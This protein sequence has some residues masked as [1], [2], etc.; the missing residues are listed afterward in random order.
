MPNKENF[1]YYWSNIV[2][3]KQIPF[4]IVGNNTDTSITIYRPHYQDDWIVYTEF[5]FKIPKTIDRYGGVYHEETDEISA[6]TFLIRITKVKAMFVGSEIYTFCLD[7]KFVR[8]KSCVFKDN[9]PHPIL[10]GDK[11]IYLLD[12]HVRIPLS[13]LP[14]TFTDDDYDG[15]YRYYHEHIKELRPHAIKLSNFKILEQR[16]IDL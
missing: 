12:D 14:K 6:I 15:F 4:R 10:L 9:L 3:G 13:I 11:Y 5:L 16:M 1:K 8:F 2:Y 7:D